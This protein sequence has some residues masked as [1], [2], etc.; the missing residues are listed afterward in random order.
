[1]KMRPRGPAQWTCLI[2]L[3]AVNLSLFHLGQD[4]LTVRGAA[5]AQSVKPGDAVV[6]SNAD[7]DVRTIQRLL[8]QLS[9][10]D[11]KHYG[12]VNPGPISGVLNQRTRSA[13]RNFMRIKGLNGSPKVDRNLWSQLIAA[14]LDLPPMQTRPQPPGTEERC[15]PNVSAA[16]CAVAADS[17]PARPARK[18]SPAL[19]P[20][21]ASSSTPLRLSA[22]TPGRPDDIGTVAKKAPIREFTAV[23]AVTAA[24]GRSG[25]EIPTIRFKRGR[26]RSFFIQLASL[27]SDRAA[28]NEWRKISDTN[29]AVLRQSGISIEKAVLKGDRVYFRLLTGPFQDLSE[30][31]HVCTVLKRN[32]QKCLVQTRRGQAVVIDETGVPIGALRTSTVTAADR[33]P[34]APPAQPRRPI[35]GATVAPLAKAAE[36]ANERTDAGKTEDTVPQR[37]ASLALPTPA[38]PDDRSGSKSRPGSTIAS[39]DTIATSPAA[40]EAEAALPHEDPAISPKAGNSATD[41]GDHVAVLSKG[42]VIVPARGAS[43]SPAPIVGRRWFDVIFQKIWLFLSGW[44]G[45]AIAILAAG[46]IGFRHFRS[47]RRSAQNAA[48]AE[49]LNAVDEAPS[50]EDVDVEGDLAAQFIREFD[51]AQLRESRSACDKFLQKVFDVSDIAEAPSETDSSA[52]LVNSRLKDLLSTEPS[53]YKL[54]FLN[55]VFLNQVGVALNR[56]E[57]L[58]EQLDRALGREVELVRSYF[59]IHLLELDHRHHLCDRLPGLF[60]CLQKADR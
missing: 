30:A 54:I 23:T 28:R 10:G 53:K 41:L 60:Y 24:R 39:P 51:R 14:Q 45:A 58:M 42:V 26:E 9:D 32:K 13:I 1:M 34:P 25:A 7:V 49:A 31:R 40:S 33:L 21:I 20:A 29:I 48:F 19:I 57:L 52:M 22:P 27:V 5:F 3:C 44:G 16:A 43:G 4:G 35:V 6:A 50:V 17:E 47:R 55:W 11:P 59:K 38:R 18:E 12:T 2:L 37:Q 46:W 8:H 56:K 36:S 15:G